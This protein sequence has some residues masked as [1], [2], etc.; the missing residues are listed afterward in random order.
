[1]ANP[2]WTIVW[3]ITILGN[4]GDGLEPTDRLVPPGWHG[5]PWGPEASRARKSGEIPPLPITPEMAKWDRWGKA[6][7]RDGD[8]LFRRGNATVLRGFF[9]FSR[10][11]ASISGSQFS[12]TGIAAIED[13]EPV[14]YDITKAGVRRQPLSIWVLDNAGPFGAKRVKPELAGYAAKAVVFCRHLYETQPPFDFELKIDDKA[15]Y[16]IE[17]TE[18]AYRNNGL[19]L[20][21]PVLLGDMENVTKYPFTVFAFLQ[22]SGLT[23]DQPVYFPGN[24]RHGIWSSK[25]LLTVYAPPAS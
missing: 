17:M 15:F 20:A 7:L 18:K 13:G 4:G 14:V 3:L 12:H 21:D 22:F 10:F 9:P 24:D 16:C 5:N 23:L 6:N 1:M 19:P 25:H 11:L 8:I 2:M